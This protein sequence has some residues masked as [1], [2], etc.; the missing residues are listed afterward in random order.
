MEYI[1]HTNSDIDLNSEFVEV[2][3]HDVDIDDAVIATGVN[4][5]A[6]V[7]TIAEGNGPSERVGRGINIVTIG[8]RYD[9]LLPTTTAAANTSDIVRVLLVVDKQCNGAL[10]AALD[11]LTTASYKSFYNLFNSHRFSIILDRVHNLSSESG[12][13]RGSTDTLSYGEFII[14][15]DLF[16]EVDIPIEYDNS[17][18]DG[19]IGTIRSNNLV[20]VLCSKTGV[21]SFSSTIRIRYTEE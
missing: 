10:P 3:F 20:V 7:L 6:A 8:W 14:E 15:D 11:I 2:K 21:T 5:Q 13:G 16:A 19:S 4:I 12:S 9:I 1:T 18:T 17:A